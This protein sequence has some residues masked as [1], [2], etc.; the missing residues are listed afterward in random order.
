MDLNL[1]AIFFLGVL[2][3]MT[4]AFAMRGYIY[5]VERRRERARMNDAQRWRRVTRAD[6]ESRGGRP[7]ERL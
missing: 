1:L 6:W 4:F 3:G 2:A 5:L 7:R